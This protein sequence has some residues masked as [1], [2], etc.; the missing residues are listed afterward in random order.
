MERIGVK[1]RESKIKA[2]SEG[3]LWTQSSKKKEKT[4]Q[5]FIATVKDHMKE[6]GLKVETATNQKR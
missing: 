6:L 2:T 4:T 1:H 5:E 3:Q